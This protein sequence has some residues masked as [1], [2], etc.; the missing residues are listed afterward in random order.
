MGRF[1]KSQ[2][3]AV[4]QSRAQRPDIITKLDFLSGRKTRSNKPKSQSSES[5]G[6]RA[7]GIKYF[8]IA[9]VSLIGLSGGWML[10]QAWMNPAQ[11]AAIEPPIHAEESAVGDQA[12][13]GNANQSALPE[14]E[15]R[16]DQSVDNYQSIYNSARNPV[17]ARRA[18]P[19]IS[20][21]RRQQ[22][23]A[24]GPVTTMLKPF[25]AINPM[26]LRKFRPW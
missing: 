18:V 24:A 19:R 1:A 15:A 3:V 14:Q 10:G 2:D 12:S 7:K 8:V 25:K 6:Q 23:A 13:E 22:A 11:V 17:K 21:A 20:R 4:S 16:Q 26:K 5:D 9:L